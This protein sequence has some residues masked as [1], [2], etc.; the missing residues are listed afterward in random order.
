M[1]ERIYPQLFSFEGQG[2]KKIKTISFR[3]IGNLRFLIVDY[4][5]ENI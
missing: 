1:L 5:I 4:V 3:S 2:Y